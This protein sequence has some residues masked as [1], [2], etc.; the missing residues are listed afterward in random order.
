[1]C[2]VVLILI[3]IKNWHNEYYIT[4]TVNAFSRGKE[5]HE[6]T[7]IFASLWEIRYTTFHSYKI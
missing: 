2:V 4:W 3:L 1:M 5:S 7:F 6:S